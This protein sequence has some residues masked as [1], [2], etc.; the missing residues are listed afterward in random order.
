MKLLKVNEDM[1]RYKISSYCS[2][3]WSESRESAGK[4]SLRFPCVTPVEETSSHRVTFRNPSTINDGAPLRKQSTGLTRSL[5]PQKSS[6][7]DLRTDSKYG[8]D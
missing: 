5:F 3:V 7:S 2:C 4:R 6:T 8:S 1:G